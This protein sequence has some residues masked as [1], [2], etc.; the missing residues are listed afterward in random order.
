MK[1]TESSVA[2]KIVGEGNLQSQYEQEVVEL[3][4]EKKV[5]FLGRLSEDDLI[6]EYQTA[7]L[8]ILPS[9]NSHEAFGLVIIEAM[10]CGLPVIASDLPGVRTVF[11]NG[12]EGLLCQPNNIN[13]LAQKIDEVLLDEDKRKEMSLNAR[14]LA[15]ESYSWE[16]IAD[17]VLDEFSQLN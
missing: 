7:D 11:K 14:I 17:S 6:Y 15:E 1:Q 5:T 12:K 8:L 3:G 9:I 2:L 4:L 16:K 13:D 10:A